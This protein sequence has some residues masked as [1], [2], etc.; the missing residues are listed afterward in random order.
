MVRFSIYLIQKFQVDSTII[1]TYFEL[2]IAGKTTFSHNSTSSRFSYSV[3]VFWLVHRSPEFGH[4]GQPEHT[5]CL[6]G[7]SE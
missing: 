1:N 4:I 7:E 2:L 5:S 6:T 3:F